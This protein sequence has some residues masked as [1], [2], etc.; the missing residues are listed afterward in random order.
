MSNPIT[1]QLMAAITSGDF[2]TVF[3]TN[4]TLLLNYHDVAVKPAEDGANHL[5][6]LCMLQPASKKKGFFA[7]TP[8]QTFHSS[9]LPNP[10]MEPT[11]IETCC[12]LVPEPL[13]FGHFTPSVPLPFFKMLVGATEEDYVRQT[14]RWS[15]RNK[16]RGFGQPERE[17][18][19]LSVA[20]KALTIP[21]GFK[22]TWVVW[23]DGEVVAFVDENNHSLT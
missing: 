16:L 21:S 10:I 4:A 12:R 13:F 19:S 18:C 5:E 2:S 11:P 9:E 17:G 3:A 1:D 20:R 6:V 15:R 23:L 8:T 7:P 22:L 14:W